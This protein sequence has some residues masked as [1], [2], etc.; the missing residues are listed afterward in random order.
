M[1]KSIE[2]KADKNETYTVSDVNGLIEETVSSQSAAIALTSRSILSTV[3]ET[4]ATKQALGGLSETVGTMSTAIEQTSKDIKLKADSSTTYTKE[5]VNGLIETE[6]RNRN[7]AIEVGNSG[8]L[9]T[10]SNTY[11]TKK[12]FRNLGIGGRNYL[13]FTKEFTDSMLTDSY[14]KNITDSKGVA[15]GVEEDRYLVTAHSGLVPVD[16]PAEY[17][18]Y[19]FQDFGTRDLY[20][21][22]TG[23]YTNR[24][25]EFA[26]YKNVIAPI[27]GQSYVFSFYAKGT[28]KL[29]AYFY[30]NP[31]GGTCAAVSSQDVEN[32][33]SD[34]HI[35][36]T[37]EDSWTRY[38]VKWTIGGT[39]DNNAK[40]NV[41]LRMFYGNPY[42]QA[43]VCA[44]KFEEGTVP[45]AWSPAIE[46]A[47]VTLEE[48]QESLLEELRKN[49]ELIN[50][51]LIGVGE[52][53]VEARA[54]FHVE[55]DN[56][57]S[58]VSKKTDKAT[59]I[60]TINQS[61]EE[62]K[63][64]ADRITLEGTTTFSSFARTSDIPTSLSQLSNEETSFA[65]T[66]DIPTKL[67]Q[68][69]NDETNYQTA[70]Q[71]SDAIS[72]GT[73]SFAK[74]D[75]AITS[76]SVLYYATDG[77]QP[78]KPTG[79]T[80]ITDATGN[81]GRWTTV[82]PALTNLITKMFICT[83]RVTADGKASWSDVVRDN[84]TTNFSTTY[85]TVAEVQTIY[86][87]ND[88]DSVPNVPPTN[89]SGWITRNTKLGAYWTRARPEHISGFPYVYSAVQT[90]F[91][92]GTNATTTPIKDTLEDLFSPK[93][94]TVAD[95]Q[96]V[97]KSAG[98][99]V[100]T[101]DRP[102][103]WITAT[104]INDEDIQGDWTTIRPKLHKDYPNL[105][106]SKQVKTLNGTV[107]STLP[108]K[109][110]SLTVIDGGYISTGEIDASKVRINNL[111]VESIGGTDAYMTLS[112]VENNLASLKKY[113]GVVQA[114]LITNGTFSTT[115]LNG[116]TADSGSFSM[117][118]T[119]DGYLHLSTTSSGRKG[120][121]QDVSVDEANKKYYV[122]VE[123]K[124]SFH[125]GVGTSTS[126]LPSESAFDSIGNNKYRFT[127]TSTSA[128]VIRIYIFA[129]ASTATNNGDTYIK[130]ISVIKDTKYSGTLPI[131]EQI[132][133]INIQGS[134]SGFVINP[135]TAP[136]EWVTNQSQYSS[137]A[138]TNIR[139]QYNP[140]YRLTY[141]AKQTK[142]LNGNVVTTTPVRDQSMT[143]IDGGTITTGK[144]SAS[145]ID[146]ENI[147]ITS[148]NT[149]G[150]NLITDSQTVYY[151]NR[152]NS[153]GSYWVSS[154]P[155][156]TDWVI[157]HGNASN[158]W[159]RTR[160]SR[161]GSYGG[162]L[163]KSTQTKDIN[164]NVHYTTPIEDR[165]YDVDSSKVSE[166]SYI[167]NSQPSG[168]WAS[169]VNLPTSWVTDMT[170]DQGTWTRVRPKY[171]S[172]YPVLFVTQQ[173]RQFDNKV[174]FAPV[175]IDETTTIIDG[176][177]IITGTID[178]NKI[179]TGTLKANMIY[180]DILEGKTITGDK[181]SGGTLE[182][183]KLTFKNNGVRTRE[184]TASYITDILFNWNSCYFIANINIGWLNDDAFRGYVIDGYGW[185]SHFDGTMWEEYP[186]V[187]YE[188]SFEVTKY[189][190]R[191]TYKNGIAV[192]YTNSDFT[193]DVTDSYRM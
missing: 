99:G 110:E 140:S 126:G 153:D 109:D 163:Y 6:I 113:V 134:S 35:T 100:V 175:K 26:L 18:E 121:R 68:L 65:R 142:Y 32:S 85:Q 130:N 186:E 53:V 71:I 63:I 149:E 12:D 147:R 36:F 162:L 93:S 8:V 78:N 180:G 143:I 128:K 135:P 75:T 152:K 188:V 123:V 80:P 97:Y 16:A 173:S 61:P 191:V 87:A 137:G 129:Y 9:T 52:S 42:N 2:L 174:T 81:T 122:T 50:E 150:S 168:T 179:T 3:S 193:Y 105:F 33:N 115:E 70:K 69:S 170:G 57:K 131:A 96:Y 116:W 139:P 25:E 58:E 161:Q 120:F 155:N 182:I 133:Y 101:M 94:D 62:I 124:D 151:W 125:V 187:V 146:V 171:E 24:Y 51:K 48:Y 13:M 111:T 118:M 19:K 59:I 55:A 192:S 158:T 14:G 177:R 138:W 49:G 46:D 127:V 15:F 23:E 43:V 160:P 82:R 60:S 91:A 22:G 5:D 169:E 167:Y 103:G 183:G 86:Y 176:G 89:S 164:G 40:R 34:G 38:W 27:P 31:T 11:T 1:R 165:G 112:D 67:S 10:V 148:L 178:A 45:T 106:I 190:E 159:L 77:N 88:V 102:R 83:Q 37:L 119:Q 28:G 4:Y 132:I 108:I 90:R 76:S 185:N 64:S 181:I 172:N 144:V 72:A 114:E 30:P 92:S 184:G 141:L 66:G 73:T 156:P 44:L 154:I 21:S 7:S 107:N 17:N 20:L 117:E 39:N 95:T 74:K 189:Y 79:T 98:R 54:T 29:D 47:G 56:I 84:T 145:Y 157:Q 136:F 104:K 166:T 41:L